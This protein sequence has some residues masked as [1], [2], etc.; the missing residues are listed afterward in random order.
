MVIHSYTVIF[1]LLQTL[2]IEALRALNVCRQC[3]QYDL[4]Y[5]SHNIWGYKCVDSPVGDEVLRSFSKVI[6]AI[7]QLQVQILYL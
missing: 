2:I 3:Y 7:P 1:I 5:L 6:V 4:E